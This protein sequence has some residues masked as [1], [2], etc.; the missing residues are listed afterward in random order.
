ME[1]DNLSD[2]CFNL[3][4]AK[5]SFSARI[6]YYISMRVYRGGGLTKDAV[7]LA[8]LIDLMDYLKKGGNLENLYTGKFNINHIELIEELLYRNVLKQPELP[9]FL[10]R[11]SVK[12]RLKKLRDGIAITELVN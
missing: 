7:Y 2:R 1:K 6:A 4:K 12:L 9:R 8:G 10:E 5:Y 3:L 11:E